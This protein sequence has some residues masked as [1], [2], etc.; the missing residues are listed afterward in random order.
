M[1]ENWGR[2]LSNYTVTNIGLVWK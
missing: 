2:G 1:C